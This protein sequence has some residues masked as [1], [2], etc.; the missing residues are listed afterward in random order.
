MKRFGSLA[1]L[2]VVTTLLPAGLASGM[3][4]A[5]GRIIAPAE[6]VEPPRSTPLTVSAT[7]GAAARPRAMSQ[8][9]YLDGIRRRNIF[10]AAYIEAYNPAAKAGGDGVAVTDLKLK[11][12]ATMVAS[13]VQF[14]SALIAGDAGSA[15][16]AIGDEIRG[17]GA[18]IVDIEV[19]RVKI[20]GADGGESYLLM[21]QEAPVPV[22]GSDEPVAST[23]AN[24]FGVEALGENRYAI[25]KDTIAKYMADPSQLATMGRALLHRGPDGEYDGYRL[26][27]IR[28]GTLADALG[29]KNGDVVNSINGTPLNSMQ[30]AMGAGAAFTSGGGGGPMQIE[31]TRRGQKMTLDYEVR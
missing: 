31:I 19:S 9:A 12:L 5:L 28:R 14:S 8:Q 26:S 2:L 7:D 6:L 4:L 20:R 29:I 15:G 16:Y 22:S 1:L 18:R 3:N 10:D 30:A 23:S 13:P 21:E 11:L 24:E 27:A 25:S 17:T